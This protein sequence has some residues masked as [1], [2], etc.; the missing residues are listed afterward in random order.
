MTRAASVQRSHRVASIKL[1]NTKVSYGHVDTLDAAARRADQLAQEGRSVVVDEWVSASKGWRPIRAVGRGKN[2]PWAA[3]VTKR[4]KTQRAKQLRFSD[5]LADLR[6]APPRHVK[7]LTPQQKRRIEDRRIERLIQYAK[8]ETRID[9][10]RKEAIRAAGPRTTAPFED[11]HK[12][13]HGYPGALKF[14]RF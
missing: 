1:P 11:G 6:V 9:V 3:H 8:S 10:I 7:R 12:R 14:R 4:L 5:F 2:Q 13:V